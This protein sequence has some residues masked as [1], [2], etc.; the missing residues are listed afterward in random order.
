[1]YENKGDDRR[2]MK[3]EIMKLLYELFGINNE[4]ELNIALR[5]AEKLNIGAMTTRIKDDKDK[6]VQRVGVRR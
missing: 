1:M 2:L 5:D 6:Q 3:E 4:K